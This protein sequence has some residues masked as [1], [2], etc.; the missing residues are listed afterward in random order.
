MKKILFLHLTFVLFLTSILGQ[1]FIPPFNWSPGDAI[2]AV[3]T[4]NIPG[5]LT[6]PTSNNILAAPL[7]TIDFSVRF[8]DFDR[9]VCSPPIALSTTQIYRRRSGVTGHTEL[10]KQH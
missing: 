5:R 1:N 4:A 8:T 6:I 3:G 9:A 2:G 7:S 10:R